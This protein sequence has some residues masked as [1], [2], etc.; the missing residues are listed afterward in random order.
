MTAP[1]LATDRLTLVAHHPDHLDALA[2]LWAEPAVYAMIGGAPR[3]REEVWLRL[4]R[5][6]GQWQAF[7]YGS[8]VIR[9]VEGRVIGEGGLMEARR[10][11]D[12]PLALPEANWVLA[13][14]AHGKGYAAEALTAVF[15]WAEAHGIPRTTCIIDPA[16]TA[17]LRLAAKLGYRAVRDAAYNG[18]TVCVLE[19]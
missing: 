2:A 8:W 7:G 4:L 5:S 9:D 13:P 1:T 16:N 15:G 3:S 6:I 11:I 18:R 10:A 12:P 14:A 17:S 19:R